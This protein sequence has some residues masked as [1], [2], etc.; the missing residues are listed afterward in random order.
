MRRF[1]LMLAA[2]LVGGSTVFGQYTNILE[3]ATTQTVDSAWNVGAD[4][5]VG[6]LTSNNVLYVVDGGAVSNTNG[7]VGQSAAAS[8][9]A[10]AVSGADAHWI[11]LGTLNVGAVSNAGNSVSVSSGGTI[12]AGSLVVA[13]DNTFNLNRAGTLTMSGG[14]DAAM[15]GFN[16]KAG[17]TLSVGG[18]LT[19]LASTNSGDYLA[20]EKHLVLN[21]GTFSGTTN[22]VVGYESSGNTLAITNGGGVANADGYIGWGTNAANNAVLVAGA[23]SAWTNSGNLHVGGGAG[24][25][26][27]LTV[28]NSAWVYVGGADTNLTAL[29]SGGIAVA[30]NATMAVGGG[31]SVWT[32][33]LYI[34]D[35]GEVD[36]AGA[37]TV[38]GAFDAG[39]AGF[40]WNDGADLTVNGALTLN[41]DLGGSNRTLTV[42]G[43]SWNRGADLRVGGVGTSLALLNGGTVTNADGYVGTAAADTNT[44]VLVS[45]AG[46]LWVNNG[47]LNI[48]SAETNHGNRVAVESGGR[49][50]ADALNVE[51]NNRFDLNAGGTLAMSGIFDVAAQSNLHWNTGGNLSVGG[52]LSGVDSTTNEVIGS[53]TYLADGQILTIDGGRWIN[54]DDHLI[55]GYNSD[56]S[57]LV[58]ANGGTVDNANGYIGWGGV[59]DSNSVWVGAGSAW[60][61][62]G[63]GLYVGKW[64]DGSTNLVD[65]YSGNSLSVQSN[66]WVFV[67]EGGTNGLPVGANGGI[68]VA[69]TNG[70][71]LVVGGNGSRVE[72]EQRLYVGVDATS[73]GTVWV[74]HGGVVVAD[75]LSIATNSMFEL[76]GALEIAEGFNVSQDGFIWNDGGSLSVGGVLTG[77][78]VLDGS[79]RTVG[80]AGG[81]WS[82][83]LGVAGVGN[84][85]AVTAG[86]QLSSASAFIGFSSNDVGNVVSV[87]DSGSVWNLTGNLV[88]NPG[89]TLELASTGLVSV[90]GN[91]TVSNATVAG[92]GTVEL[93][94]AASLLSI[95]GTNSQLSANVLFDGNGG[96]AAFTDGELAV[97]GS[98]SNRFVNFD[99]LGLTNSTLSGT[100]TVD[101]FDN[102]GMSGGWIK[103]TGV[104]SIDG[105]FAADGT[106]LQVSVGAGSNLLHVTSGL[107]LA[108]MG[109]EVVVLDGLNP[110][111]FNQMILEADGGVTNTFNADIS[112]IT[113]HYMLY[114]FA[115]V[116]NATTVSVESEAAVDGQISSAVSYAGVQGVRAGFNGMRNS[117]FGRTKQLRRNRVATD[118]AIPQEAYLMSQTNAPSGAY[119]PGDRN[120]IFDMHFW[121]QQFSGT[122][123]YDASGNT[124]G[125][126]LDNNGTTFGFDRFF[127]D[128]LVAGINYTYARSDALAT[129]GDSSNTETYWLGLY[130]EWLRENG[131]YVDALA[132]VGRS[133]YDTVRTETGYR[134]IGSYRGIDFGG[135]V[136]VGRY[137]QFGDWALAPY[138]GMRYLWI[139]SDGYAESDEYGNPLRVDGLDVASLESAF[140]VKLRNR[141]DTR[142]GRFQT[143]GYAEWLYDFIND[144]VSTT[145]SDGTTTVQTAGISPDA[146]LLSAGIGL[147]WICT[148]YMEIGIG[149]DGR[150]NRK[151]EEHTGSVMLDIRF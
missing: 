39:Q 69:S 151:Y 16:W 148:D 79:N 62:H 119:G 109:A 65:A 87:S 76:D 101:G 71:E 138:A 47:S 2:V 115:L 100:G 19:G 128:N 44:A 84:T 11:N 147:G 135:T 102:V 10:V 60:T 17:G 113:E 67:G 86:G 75:G 117:L 121:A 149:Y 9:N 123:D 14:F 37:L 28:S 23:G 133:N 12:Q 88:V 145:L 80:I 132:G 134:G 116:T 50:E 31:A 89:N 77:L 34:D 144:D 52:A 96:A 6:D 30:S 140:G 124:A 90:A 139:G 15:D 27:T 146:N 106:I 64:I 150:F 142:F 48:G 93:G 83:F 136:D 99:R 51:D 33:G 59:A 91:M 57:K 68:V 130:A 92:S 58:I 56:A 18:A 110:L 54:G 111:G 82:N 55:V 126:S 118:Y 66:G 85:V 49:I 20:G 45:G 35:A 8:N 40:N 141:I 107:D 29:G 98:L 43:G 105:V 36:L 1:F 131:W 7:F 122:G 21:S 24:A 120:T 25:G 127:G 63:G 114:D 81:S 13:S 94:G 129:Q 143:V 137:L 74:A 3:N 70:A 78:D 5:W 95:Y 4:L 26:N 112:S 125:F 97:S 103:P 41:A 104:L 22:L 61:N 72:V 53:A 108:A 42:D 38:K 46:S 73:T 32:D